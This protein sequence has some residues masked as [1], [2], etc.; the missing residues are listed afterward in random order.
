MEKEIDFHPEPEVFNSKLGNWLEEFNFKRPNQALEYK[1][2]I[3]F[4]S[5][6]PCVKNVLI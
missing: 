5:E 3:E 4:V 2:P 1:T 6:H